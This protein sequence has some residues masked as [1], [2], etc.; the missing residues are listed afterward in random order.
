MNLT[1]GIRTASRQLVRELGFMNR[2]LAGTRLTPSEVH[3]I[4][5]IGAGNELS[6]KQLA[7]KLILE[8]S[9]VSRLLSSL[10]AAGELRETRSKPDARRK[11]LRLTAKGGK[12]LKAIDRFAERQVAGAV[13][14]LDTATRRQIL[15]GLRKYAIA[16]EKSRTRAAI[17][18]GSNN[19]AIEEGYTPGLIVRMVA[20]HAAYYSALTG[21]GA[22]FEATLAGGLADFVGRL[23]C[24]DNAVWSIRAS[25]RVVGGVA[26]DGQDLGHRK[27]HLRW[28]IVDETL[29]GMGLGKML[30]QKAVAFCDQRDF[31]ETHL[32]TFRGLDAA[33]HLYETR[34]FRLTEER[35]GDQWGREVREQRFVRL[36][37]S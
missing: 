31:P 35:M 25:A 15:L 29:R 7:E 20:I 11:L 27:A 9:T 2:T 22:S 23:G 17:P 14:G 19:V 30:L 33:R 16:L 4:V 36:K 3:A 28:F 24:A 8:K 32:W 10:I 1:A 6:A 13:D 18:T 21:F 12:T 26:V 34:G 5:E 37:P